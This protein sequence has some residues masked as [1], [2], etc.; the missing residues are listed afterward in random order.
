MRPEF[1]HLAKERPK[2]EGKSAKKQKLTSSEKHSDKP[3]PSQTKRT[4]DEGELE[5]PKKNKSAFNFFVKFNRKKTEDELGEGHTTEE[6]KTKLLKKWEDVDRN[7][8]AAEY[9]EMADQDKLRYER[10]LAEYEKQVKTKKV[11]KI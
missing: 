9:M 10:E 2:A 1:E 3:S 11:K 5:P 7:G 6:L 8:Q 4:R